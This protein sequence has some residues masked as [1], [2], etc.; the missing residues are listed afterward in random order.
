MI[1]RK[2]KPNELVAQAA[3]LL[4]LGMALIASNRYVTFIAEEVRTLNAAGN[5][6]ACWLLFFLAGPALNMFPFFTASFCIF[7]S[8]GPRGTL[9]IFAFPRSL[10]SWRGCFFLA[11]QP[12]DSR[13]L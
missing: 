6:C 13:V 12:T 9:N 5:P 7:G 11:A 3:P 2:R 8:A 4:L 1:P 10:F